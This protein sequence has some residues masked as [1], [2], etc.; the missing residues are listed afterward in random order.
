M[1]SS[2]GKEWVRDAFNAFLRVK[3]VTANCIHSRRIHIA[4]VFRPVEF[5]WGGDEQLMQLTQRKF[6]QK[7]TSK[8]KV[9]LRSIFPIKFLFA[10]F[11]F[12]ILKLMILSK[13]D[14]F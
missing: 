2:N 13:E 7:H 12:E 10:S 6:S 9:D 5:L 3:T 1:F 11:H 4:I 8:Q 14:S